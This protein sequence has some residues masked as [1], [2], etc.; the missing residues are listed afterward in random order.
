[1]MPVH[2]NIH[3]KLLKEARQLGKHRTYKDA[4]DAALM[5]Y[6]KY[7]GQTENTEPSENMEYDDLPLPRTSSPTK[8]KKTG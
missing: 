2:M 1:M 7:H 3:R 4:L 6:V 8:A 5:E